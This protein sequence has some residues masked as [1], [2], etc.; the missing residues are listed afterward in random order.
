MRIQLENVGII[1]KCDVEFVP[2]INL[3]IGSSGSGKSTLMRCIYNIATNEFTDSDI[4]F[5]KNTMNVR[6]EE[7]ENVIEYSRSIKAKGER[8]YYK[9]NGETYVKL[10]RQSLP[11]VSDALKIGDIDI[12]GDNINFNFNLQFSSPFL[13]L[14]NQSTLYNVLT[15]RSTYDISSIND[16]YA[17]DI[18]SNA[19]ETASNVKLKERLEANLESLEAQAEK[20]SPIEQLY[21]DYVAYKH[22]AEIVEDLKSILDKTKQVFD[23]SDKLTVIDNLAKHVANAELIASKLDEITSYS[24]VNKAFHEVNNIIGSKVAVIC[25]YENA[26]RIIQD[27]IQLNKLLKSMRQRSAV[28][29]NINVL[30]KCLKGCTNI[31]NKESLV[32]DAI[33]QRSIVLKL[34]K[35][36]R[37]V[38]ILTKC[39]G[40]TITHV[41]DLL[42]VAKKLDV[43][44][45]INNSISNIESKCNT[46]NEEISKFKVCPLCGVSLDDHKSC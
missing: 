34:E 29:S 16:Y 44:H 37:I 28:T 20:L 13:I 43:L 18:R 9:V 5:G 17:A 24:K 26:I 39:D 36:N 46:V 8:C 27:V 33:K 35:C 15:Y 19:S 14:G 11:A 10:G 23:L 38:N 32:N 45:S 3:I 40:A 41:D 22:K 4:S 25:H 2:G 6:V 31:L 30:N 42:L 21:S 7:D 1:S 12:N